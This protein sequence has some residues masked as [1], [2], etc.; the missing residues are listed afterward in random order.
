MS[1]YCYISGVIYTPNDLKSYGEVHFVPELRS[2]KQYSSNEVDTKDL[3]SGRHPAEG[4]FKPIKSSM[5]QR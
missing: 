5:T 1:K 4:S 2:W 3:K